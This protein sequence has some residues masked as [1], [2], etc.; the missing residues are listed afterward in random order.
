MAMLVLYTD[1]ESILLSA[2]HRIGVVMAER[3]EPD[4]PIRAVLVVAAGARRGARL[5]QAARQLLEARGVRLLGEQLVSGPGEALERVRA[6][7]YNDVPLVVV[8][9]GDG[10]LRAVL[11][12]IARCDSVLGILPLGTANNFAR[13]VGVPMD[14][15][16]AIDTIV[17][18]REISV[19]LGLINGE[20][21]ANN[22]SIGFSRDIV[23]AT[24][25]GLK[26]WLGALSYVFFETGYILRQ[27][28]FCCTVATEAGSTRFLTRHLMT[29][30]GAHYGTRP[31]AP[32]ARLDDG[33]LDLLALASISK[34]QGIRFWAR[35]ILGRHLHDPELRRFRV[36]RATITADPPRT[37]IV[38][39]ERGPMTPV[40]IAAAPG[41]LRVMAPREPDWPL[42]PR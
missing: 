10:T 31:I 9:G 17:D 12:A 39:G 26:R 38:D 37:V 13:S 11:P 32:E 42:T 21:F 25:H 27:R 28:L 41:A 34:W 18:G 20:F 5:Y 1:A 24:P 30:N 16:G 6:A 15:V 7:V 23:S 2:R 36:E 14:L 29:V 3:G 4:E 35:F 40:E 22:L 8:G 33:L 19:D